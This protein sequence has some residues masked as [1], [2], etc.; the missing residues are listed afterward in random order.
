MIRLMMQDDVPAVMD[1]ELEAYPFPWT[2]GIFRDCLRVGYPGWVLE[3]EGDIIGYVMISMGAGESHLLNLCIAPDFQGQGL[4]LG[5]LQ[6]VMENVRTLECTRMFLEVR[7][8]NARAINLYQ[9]FGFEEI[10][11]RKD[12]YPA[13][14]GREDARVFVFDLA[15]LGQRQP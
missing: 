13:G 5:L 10:G 6:Q 1:I 14:E 4:A 11:R 8:S 12:Y 7:E 2:T 9:R 15:E 3:R